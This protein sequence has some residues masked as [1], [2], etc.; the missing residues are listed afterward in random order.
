MK[1]ANARTAALILC[2]GI[3]ALLLGSVNAGLSAP[4]FEIEQGLPHLPSLTGPPH[5]VSIETGA[6]LVSASLYQSGLPVS[7]VA[8]ATV[9][10]LLDEQGSLP[11]LLETNSSGEA[12]AQIEAG[13]YTLT[14]STSFFGTL[15]DVRV[16]P[17]VTT[18][19]DVAFSMVSDQALFSDL[20][21][22]DSSGYVA[23]WESIVLA[24]D[25]SPGIP[26]SSA[27]FLDLY[28]SQQN[29]GV[30]QGHPYLPVPYPVT[31]V[32][33][34]VRGSGA[35]GLLWLTLRPE[36]FVPLQNATILSVVTYTATTR[37]T[38]HGY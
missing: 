36:T 19:A 21:D 38:L 10:I 35:S 13:N 16:Y 32:A 37:I 34:Q 1:R 27:Y 9:K 24:V 17:N 5:K 30:V 20:P 15:A 2:L 28:P 3:L 22:G 11:L 6:I 4:L 26:N 7:P 14:V 31:I 8:N 23:P 25:A 18:D 33:S 29:P 12:Q